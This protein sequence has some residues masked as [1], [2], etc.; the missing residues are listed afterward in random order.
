MGG[1]WVLGWVEGCPCSRAVCHLTQ[2]RA[3]L[4]AEEQQEAAKAGRAANAHHLHFLLC[5]S[6]E[7]FLIRVTPP[8]P[9]GLTA[10]E[11]EE[12]AKAEELMRAEQGEDDDEGD[13]KKSAKVGWEC[14]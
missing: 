11:A 7:L 8:P 3:G 10:E 6:P 2:P 4:A 13:Y 9:P 1:G 12:K 5:L 14:G